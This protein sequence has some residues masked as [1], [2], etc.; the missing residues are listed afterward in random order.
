L[1]A[2]WKKTIPSG[3]LEVLIKARTPWR[4][5][6]RRL[7]RVALRAL[8]G[9][10]AHVGT[11]LEQVE[12]QRKALLRSRPRRSFWKMAKP[13]SSQAHHLPID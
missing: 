6:R 3:V 7:A 1:Q 2:C 5:L 8:I 4:A 12:A 10:P 11:V 9:A 13:R